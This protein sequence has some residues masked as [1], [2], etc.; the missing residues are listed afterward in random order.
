MQLLLN[1][2][3]RII[4]EYGYK[5]KILEALG[6]ENDKMP[7]LAPQPI[8]ERLNKFDFVFSFGC[9]KDDDF[10]SQFINDLL[11]NE[12]FNH[13]IHPVTGNLVLKKPVLA[14]VV[15]GADKY[16]YNHAYFCCY[17]FD[18][19]NTVVCEYTTLIDADSGDYAP[20]GSFVCS[21]EEFRK[22]FLHGNDIETAYEIN[23]Y[24]VVEYST[25]NTL[26]GVIYVPKHPY[27]SITEFI[28][29][30]QQILGIS[31]FANN[32]VAYSKLSSVK[33]KSDEN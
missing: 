5:D 4:N 26:N 30:A 3:V 7:I 1:N 33:V 11:G 31:P 23:E 9:F 19:L 24:A 18:R 21:T 20:V 27:T 12:D 25:N 16:S 29:E 15:T 32:N 6:V 10:T 14:V 28:T 8:A 17:F 22:L 2:I 13:F